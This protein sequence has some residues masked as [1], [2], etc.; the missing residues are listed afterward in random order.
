MKTVIKDHVLIVDELTQSDLDK[1]RNLKKKFIAELKRF[2]AGGSKKMGAA[3][4]N[5]KDNSR[6]TEIDVSF[7][8]ISNGTSPAPKNPA[9]QDKITT[10]L[11]TMSNKYNLDFRASGSKYTISGSI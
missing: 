4:T 3:I 10:T 8:A 9:T 1:S 2:Y 6:A 5:K 7:Y 11:R